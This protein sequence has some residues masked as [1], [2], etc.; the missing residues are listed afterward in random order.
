MYWN[1]GISFFGVE[2]YIVS[3]VFARIGP[4]Q[5]RKMCKFLLIEDR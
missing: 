5:N 2:I 1:I 4:Q 3:Y